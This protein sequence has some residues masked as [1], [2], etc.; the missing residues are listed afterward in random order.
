MVTRTW[1]RS[2]RRRTP[3]PVALAVAAV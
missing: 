2:V 3:G 1:F